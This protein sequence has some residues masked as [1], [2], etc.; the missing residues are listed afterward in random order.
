MFA[1]SIQKIQ[2]SRSL[3]SARILNAL[4]NTSP[5]QMWKS[6][7]MNF[8]VPQLAKARII[9]RSQAGKT[10]WKRNKWID[11]PVDTAVMVRSKNDI[12]ID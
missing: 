8:C 5:S 9:H 7:R 4:E 2:I 3:E 6:T 10:I 1:I 11:Q 12:L